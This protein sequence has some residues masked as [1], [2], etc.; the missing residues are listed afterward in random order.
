[1][2]P[3]YS[4][5]VM[6][7]SSHAADVQQC[8]QFTTVQLTYSNA[9]G[10]SLSSCIVISNSRNSNAANNCK[11]QCATLAMQPFRAKYNMPRWQCSHDVQCSQYLQST[12][13]HVG[14]AA[15]TDDAAGCIVAKNTWILYT[16]ILLALFDVPIYILA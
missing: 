5:A 2:Q 13:C 15:I 4:N 8:S 3:A 10:C 16:G 11:V 9:A 14:D 12:V 7:E 6:Q 1:M